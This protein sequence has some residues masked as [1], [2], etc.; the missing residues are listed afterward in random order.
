MNDSEIIDFTPGDEYLND[1]IKQAR[2]PEFISEIRKVSDLVS[3]LNLPPKQNNAFCD[4]LTTQTLAAETSGFYAGM[5]MGTDL[6]VYLEQ[7]KDLPA[8]TL[9]DMSARFGYDTEQLLSMICAYLSD[10]GPVASC[11]DWL[12]ML[13]SIGTDKEEMFT[14]QQA[15]GLLGVSV[16]DM[17]TMQRFDDGSA[18]LSPEFQKAILERLRERHKHDTHSD[19]E[20]PKDK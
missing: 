1:Y 12:R 7:G 19:T 11:Y 4:A 18:K 15:A 9:E 6:G 17:R 13:L 10:G 2:T 8:E 14:V 5:K 3:G 20:P 16:E